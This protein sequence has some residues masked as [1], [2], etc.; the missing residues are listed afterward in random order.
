MTRDVLVVEHIGNGRIPLRVFPNR[1]AAED[2][3]VRDCERYLAMIK[4]P[5]SGVRPVQRNELGN[6]GYDIF[7]VPMEV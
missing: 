6:L 2:W 7:V 1:E 4:H 3:C 5:R